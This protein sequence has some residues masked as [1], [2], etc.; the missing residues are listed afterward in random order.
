MKNKNEEIRSFVSRVL[1]EPTMRREIVKRSHMYFFCTYFPH[2]ITYEMAPMHHEI[3][4]IT[5][6][7]SM[8]LSVITAFRGS[9]KSTIMTLSYVL[10]SIL[11]SPQK[12]F[13]VIISQ[14][15][16]QARQHFANLKKELETNELL[17]EDL[18]PF[19]QED[20]WN[21]C[22]LILPKYNAKII[23]V[24]REQSFRGV[25]HGQYRPDLVVADDI[26]DLASVKS[27]ESRNNTYKWFTSE[28]LPLG[29]KNTKKIIIGNLLHEDSLV[30]RLTSEIEEG[31]RSGIFR[32]YP[33]LG[34]GDEIAWPGKYPDMEAIEAERKSIGDKFAWLREYLL[35]IADDQEPVIE[36]GWVHSYQELPEV[37]RN[38]GFAYAGGVD[39]AVS[40]KDKADNTAI[41][42]CKIIGDGDERKI[43]ILPNP[44]NTKM[45]LPVTIDTICTTVKS[46]GEN[47]NHIFYI[48]E[49]GTQRGLTQSLVEKNV[50][51]VGISPGRN[52]KRTRLCM[53]SEYIRSGKILFPEDGVDELMKQIL[54]FGL[55]RHDDLVDSFTTLILGIMQEPP[56]TFNIS[57]ENWS[58]I[59]K[60]MYHA[61]WNRDSGGGSEDWA[62]REDRLSRRS[63]GGMGP[64]VSSSIELGPDGQMHRRY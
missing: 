61:F 42:M 34:D 54:D 60:E 18:G 37:R 57:P 35:I 14:T 31:T 51:A 28:V 49:V 24:S 19:R 39:L 29:D 2:Y 22:S 30:M 16:E 46:L 50:K 13:V 64:G 6:D 41:V 9:G 20:S 33:L 45:A 3:F 23:A 63:G 8:P 62:D 32:K 4:R 59:R 25:K 12:K 47:S 53:V 17:R 36:K 48:E 27:E 43:Y 38:E 11:G 15:Q 5:E 55:T 58:K 26:D 52:D 1:N 44:I 10:W 21:S 40:E 56:S 7:Q